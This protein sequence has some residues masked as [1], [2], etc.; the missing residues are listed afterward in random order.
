MKASRF[1]GVNV[2]GL[3][4]QEQKIK[5][6][7]LETAAEIPEIKSVNVKVLYMDR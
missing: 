3:I 7:V 4:D 2:Q 6:R 1:A 5:Q